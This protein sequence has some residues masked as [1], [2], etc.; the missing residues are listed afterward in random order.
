MHLELISIVAGALASVAGLGMLHISMAPARARAK[1]EQ[2]LG[3]VVSNPSAVQKAWVSADGESAK[4]L[5]QVAEGAPVDVGLTNLALVSQALA[6]V[7]KR[8]GG[9]AYAQ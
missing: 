3:E 9:V 7:N 6:G 5:V 1:A 8:V 4:L 2:L